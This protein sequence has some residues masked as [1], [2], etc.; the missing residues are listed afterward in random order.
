MKL[1]ICS[2]GELFGGVERQILDLCTYFERSAAGV[3]LVVLFHDRELA[4]QLRARGIEPIILS[5]RNKYDFRMVGQ[6]ARLLAQHQIDVVHAHG[7][8]AVIACALAK[9]EYSF[10]LVKTEHGK[11]EA[12][13]A[14]PISWLKSQANFKIEQFFTRR[15]V[16][17]VCYVTRDIGS[18]F[19][20]H[21]EGMARTVVHNGMA[22][23][24]MGAFPRPSDLPEGR[25]NIGIIGR[26]TGV[27]GI[28]FALEALSREGVPSTVNSDSHRDRWAAG[29]IEG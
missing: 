17:H 20:S 18:F 16:D 19:D 1:A 21:H 23:L 15:A 12:R 24:A 10:R 4:G 7:Y 9:K 22:P 14:Q 26:V 29:G 5:G 8:K 11:L 6:L 2:V 25:F 28:P 27:K 3:P 13:I